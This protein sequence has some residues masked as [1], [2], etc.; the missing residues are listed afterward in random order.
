L[1]IVIISDVHANLAALQALPERQYDQLWCI[2]DLVDYGPDPHQVVDW[3]RRNA[4]IVVR[5]NHDYA[6]GFNADPQCSAPFKR[7]AAETLQLTLDVCTP[8]DLDYLR[9]LP[10]YRGVSVGS[11]RFYLVHATPSN[12]FFDYCPESSPNWREQVNYID[13]DVL[14][15]GHTHTPFIRHEGNTTILNPGSLGQPKT[16]RPQACYAVW[17]DGQ[18][19]LK[20]YEYPIEETIGA[21][22]AMPIAPELQDDLAAV[23]RTGSIPA[24][25]ISNAR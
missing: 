9:N 5:G 6:A 10:A 19:F 21:I 11:T 14:V 18:M 3:V 7:L 13:T 8:E 12:P 20:E 23:L 25:T 16:G 1:K 24:R 4:D 2:G 17:Q 15:V 22:R